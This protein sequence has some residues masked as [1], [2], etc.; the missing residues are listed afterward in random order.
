MAVGRH[1]P[2]ISE[3]SAASEIERR[4]GRIEMGEGKGLHRVSG[5][6][7]CGSGTAH[8]LDVCAQL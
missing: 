6:G 8:G 5:A 1:L 4:P 3:E 7:V 2:H